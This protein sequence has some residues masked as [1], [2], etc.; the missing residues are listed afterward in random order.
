[1]SRLFTLP[2]EL[3]L[4]AADYLSDRNLAAL[5]GTNRQRSELLAD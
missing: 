1:M 5:L 4:M 3:L 2:N